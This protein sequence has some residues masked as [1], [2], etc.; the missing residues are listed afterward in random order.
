MTTITHHNVQ[1]GH[2]RKGEANPLFCTQHYVNTTNYIASL[3]RAAC[4]LQNNMRLSSLS[5]LLFL[6]FILLSWR[7]VLPAM[8]GFKANANQELMLDEEITTGDDAVQ[9]GEEAH[10]EG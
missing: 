6:S 3:S 10:R 9:R 7:V 1:S 4:L 8:Q 2:K 5:E